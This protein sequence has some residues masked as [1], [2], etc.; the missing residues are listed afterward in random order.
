MNTKE[1]FFIFEKEKQKVF[2]KFYQEKK[3][4]YKRIFGKDNK[5]YDVVILVNKKWFKVE[6]KFRSKEWSDLAVETIQDTE[7]NSSGWIYYT[8]AEY[9]FYG[10][11]ERIYAINV[12]KLRILIEKHESLFEIK[13]SK[14][15][16]GNTKNIII[17]FYL[18]LDNKIGKIIK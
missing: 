17:P 10:M 13:F 4:P 8:E 9:I 18:I 11:G 16:W 12:E 2:D 15:G 7:T 6:E 1:E 5:K 14:K 3:W